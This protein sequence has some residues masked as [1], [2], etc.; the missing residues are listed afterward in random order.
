MKTKFQILIFSLLLNIPT[1]QTVEA[2]P[3]GWILRQLLMGEIK[4]TARKTVMSS[5]GKSMVKK[6][7]KRKGAMG[8][9]ATLGSIAGTSGAAEK[10]DFNY[11]EHGLVIIEEG[12]KIY[13]GKSCDAYSSAYGKGAWG[14]N[15]NGWIVAMEKNGEQTAFEYGIDNLPAFPK[16]ILNNCKIK[17]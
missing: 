15:K 17:A 2:H 8:T 10:S 1:I 5:T 11:N 3:A 12:R 6:L 4:T 7:P 16:K 14:W 9:I 13:I